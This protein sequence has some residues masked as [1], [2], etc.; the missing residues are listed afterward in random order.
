MTN[1]TGGIF[2]LEFLSQHDRI[3][4]N[5]DIPVSYTLS[6]V[7]F[8]EV[9]SCCHFVSCSEL[10]Q[11]TH[12]AVNTCVILRARAPSPTDAN[13]DWRALAAWFLTLRV[14]EFSC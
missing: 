5:Q 8:N 14:R 10:L 2:N 7:H 13:S 6:H 1:T 9:L 4:T 11:E 12:S 3:P